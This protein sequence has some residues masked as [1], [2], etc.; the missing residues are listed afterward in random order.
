M[1]PPRLIRWLPVLAALLFA[2]GL[3]VHDLAAVSFWEDESW[4]A[5]A[6][7]DGLAQVI[8]FSIEH[9]V[10]PPLY[11]VL[12]WFFR[13]A[14]GDS[15]L[16]LR[17]W[18]GL[19]TLAGL[20][21]TYRLGQAL[22]GYRAGVFAVVLAAG[23]IFL[24][25]L[26]RLARQY[27]LFYTLCVLIVYAYWRWQGRPQDSRWLVIL[28]VAQTAA[29]YT[30]YFSLWPALS[31]GLHALLTQPPRRWWR[32]AVTLA[33]S[34]AVFALWLPALAEQIRLSPAGGIGYAI[35]DNSIAL[36]NLA[37]RL[38]N[39]VTPAGLALC[40]AG[41]LAL[42]GQRRGRAGLLLLLWLAGT[43]GAVLLIN[44]RLPVYVDRNL[45]YLLPGVVVLYGS[46][47]A[48]LTGRRAGVP[49]ALALVALFIG[50]GLQAYESFWPRT[51]N[52]REAARQMLPF[53]RPD[54]VYI[55]D[56]ETWSLAYYLR[57]LAGGRRVYRDMATW[58]AAPPDHD[59]DRD[60]DRLWLID[61]GMAVNFEALAALPPGLQ[62][63]RRIV[64]LPIVAELYQRPPQEP[65]TVFGGQ[66][67]LGR[68]AP[69]AHLTAA[70]GATVTLDLWWQARRVPAAD[71]S[72]SVLLMGPDGRITGQD[73]G[74]DDGRIPAQALPLHTWIPDTRRLSIPPDTPPGTYRL[75]LTVYDWREP[76]PDLSRL[77]APGADPDHLY[78]LL[79]ITIAPAG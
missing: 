79:T 11:F 66:L 76:D 57:H 78:P 54:D 29:L 23:S 10:H 18:G 20:A 7:G 40:L 55:V 50:G 16:A 64:V 2:A 44:A 31:I 72:V 22:G 24:I 39:T 43:T 52:W 5:S 63:T 59:R 3:Y 25:Y 32:L 34:G 30:H 14:A 27:T 19:V 35:R 45:L 70:P 28:G 36:Q 33:L 21:L 9:G 53:A 60:H 62:L 65:E 71:Y 69:A 13:Q 12:T 1:T 49:V 15:E 38:F 47:L 61:P 37:D 26:T 51:Q 56:G 58:T 4:L 75:L 67:A 6:T 8:P 46:G 68:V 73:G 77:P 74:F 17:W 42:A 41:T 48:A